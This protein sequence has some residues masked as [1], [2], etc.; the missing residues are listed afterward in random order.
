MQ[1][2]HPFFKNF[3]GF[4]VNHGI[5]T[6]FAGDFGFEQPLDEEFNQ[7]QSLVQT[8]GK[9]TFVKLIPQHGDKI[10]EISDFNHLKNYYRADAAVWQASETGIDPILMCTTGDCPIV[11]LNHKKE[12][13]GI[14][15][16]GRTSTEM[17]I[18]PQTI[19]LLQDKYKVPPE[20]LEIGL[21][22]GICQNCYEL[23][24]ELAKNFPSSCVKGSGKVKLD[25]KGMILEQLTQQRVKENNISE[26]NYCSAHSTN[27]GDFL[28]PS[29]RR[30]GTMKRNVVYISL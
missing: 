8:M 24:E 28:F 4:S 6:G 14:V 19:Q 25:L 16:S 12:I 30:E 7:N 13:L 10:I 23:E 15:H 1:H 29:F 11:T 5:S 2:S 27:N 9:N 18:V 3:T 22:P 26:L 17:D 20:E 21:W